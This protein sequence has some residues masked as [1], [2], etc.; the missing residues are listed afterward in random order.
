M[1]SSIQV[2]ITEFHRLGG[3]QTASILIVWDAV[4]PKTIMPA[5]L[6][7]GKG[8][9]PGSQG[10][11][12]AVTSHGRRGNGSLWGHF[13]KSISPIHDSFLSDLN[14]FPKA[15]PTNTITLG[16]RIPHKNLRGHKHVDH[17]TPDS[18]GQ[19]PRLE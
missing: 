11:L 17:S 16:A 4:K 15:P 9:L 5:D 18:V 19:Q 14:L 3:L 2:T 12:L 13:H 6:V 10:H 8:L 1:S 7:S